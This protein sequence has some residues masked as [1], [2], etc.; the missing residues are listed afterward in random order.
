MSLSELDFSQGTLILRGWVDKAVKAVFGSDIWR[1]D[2]RINAW[3]CQAFHYINVRDA[4]DLRSVGE[5]IDR[6]VQFA[7]VVLGQV[8]LPPLRPEQQAAVDAWFATR[9]QRQA[10]PVN[11]SECADRCDTDSH[12]GVIVMPT[13]TG[14]TEVAMSIMEKLRCTALIV[15]PIRDL[16][17]QWQ[18]RILRSLGYDAGIIGDS[19]YNVKPISVTTYDS[20]CIH[21][22]TLGNQF[23][24]IIFDECHHLPSSMRRDAARM[25]VAWHRIGLTATPERTD[26]RHLDLDQLI[27]PVVYRLHI[28]EVRGKS[29]AEY[30]IFRIAVHL[31]PRE[32]GLYDKLAKQVSSYVYECRKEDAAFTWSKLCADSANDPAA[33]QAMSA[34]RQKQFIE[35]HAEE[36]NRVLED[37]FR[38]HAGQPIIVFAGSNSMARAVSRRFLIPCLLSHC[39]KKERLDYL[40]GLRDGL[41]PAII[42]NRVLDEGV[43]LP[44]VKIAIVIGGMASTKQAKQRLGRILRRSGTQEATLYEVVCKDTNETLRSRKRRASDAYARTRHRR[45]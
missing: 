39:G 1:W 31:S 22:P 36:K 30:Q 3:R 12:V 25:S 26:G 11:P 44:D 23:Q 45:M 4:L 42:A 41:Y 2:H 38:L 5:T 14:K 9:D 32:Q 40:E 6:V 24:L 16:M 29:L 28:E 20:A 10:S 17:Y 27:G 18:R 37:L 19:L 34:Y 8:S 13:G 35:D 33:R 43:D 21:M 7:P 15:A